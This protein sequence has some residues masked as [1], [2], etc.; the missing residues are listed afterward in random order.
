MSIFQISQRRSTIIRREPNL[1][2]F[3]KSLNLEMSADT[4]IFKTKG[5]IVDEV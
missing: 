1:N 3:G 2:S 4:V 5:V